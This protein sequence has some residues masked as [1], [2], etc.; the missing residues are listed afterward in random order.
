MLQLA[1]CLY[2]IATIHLTINLRGEYNTTRPILPKL[3][4]HKYYKN[5]IFYSRSKLACG[6]IDCGQM[7]RAVF[8]FGWSIVAGL[9]IVRQ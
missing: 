7:R 2:G 1:H 5:V 4:D 6:T 3:S 8:I 9:G